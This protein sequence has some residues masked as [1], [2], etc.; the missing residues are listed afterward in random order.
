[1]GEERWVVGREE[2]RYAC[3]G[4]RVETFVLVDKVAENETSQGPFESVGKWSTKLDRIPG[5]WMA[6]ANGATSAGKCDAQADAGGM[7]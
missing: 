7:R 4:L 1:M 6:I 2:I 3:L 5:L